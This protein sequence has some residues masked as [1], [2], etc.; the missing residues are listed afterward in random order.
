MNKFKVMRD[1][2]QFKAGQPQSSQ[3]ILIPNTVPE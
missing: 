2:T 3:N 1:W